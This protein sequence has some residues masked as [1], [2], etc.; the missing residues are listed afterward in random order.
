VGA[1]VALAALT[2]E[3]VTS[4]LYASPSEIEVAPKLPDGAA[5][6]VCQQY[7]T[8]SS[9]VFGPM[10]ALHGMPL[11]ALPINYA[12]RAALHTD[13]KQTT[14]NLGI[15]ASGGVSLRVRGVF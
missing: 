4:S 9:G 6:T 14:F 5:P 2:S 1:G 13:A 10:V 15:P 7:W 11:M 3:C 12:I 8:D